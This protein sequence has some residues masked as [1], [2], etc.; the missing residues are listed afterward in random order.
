MGSQYIMTKIN[1]SEDSSRF[2]CYLTV[3]S[4][5][6]PEKNTNISI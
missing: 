3:R 1:E 4:D 2:E 6:N 5:V